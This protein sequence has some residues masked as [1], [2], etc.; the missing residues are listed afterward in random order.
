MSEPWA[1]SR[2]ASLLPGIAAVA[3]KEMIHLRRD[4]RTL[5]VVFLQ[6]IVL[7]IIYGFC[8][9]F[10]LLHVPFAVWDQDR[11][12]AAR[13]VVES[14][15][16]GDRT[17]YFQFAGYVSDPRR[18]EPLLARGQVRFVLVIPP[19]F[20][21]DVAAGREAKVQAL[22]D[23]ADSNSAG[24]S[25]GYASGQ[26]S[27]HAEAVARS[28]QD[29]WHGRPALSGP[30]GSENG[31]AGAAPAPQ[32]LD[33]R[34]RVL[35]N[36]ELKSTPFIVPGLIA[37]L[38]TML[39]ALLTSTCIARERELGTLESVLI[40]PVRPVEFV[41]GKL[42]PYVLIAAGTVLLVVGIGGLMFHV[43]PRG[44]PLTLAVL[45]TL[46]LIAVLALGMLISTRAPRQQPA[47][48]LAIL[49]TMLPT[50]F[51]TG[52]AFPRGNMPVFLQWLS[53]P[54]PATQY[55]IAVR[56]VFLK[57][58]GWSVLWPQALILAAV[59]ALLLRAAVHGFVKRL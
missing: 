49:A 20:G 13:A 26:L 40:S 48:V 50:T 47:L 5:I 23:G 56:G 59:S 10:D 18:I 39:S 55:M 52:F 3:R 38:L 8:I 2:A 24:I 31:V 22:V 30:A 11:T 46:F 27:A 34:A 15:A 57:G 7:M 58:V 14:F 41:L 19:K 25:L 28:A 1:R 17:P 12:A 53:W 36:P 9:T 44:N 51:L 4:P 43:W 35:Y 45:T 32:V 54:L 16:Q 37:L 21:R 42:A 29:R 33:L 6:P